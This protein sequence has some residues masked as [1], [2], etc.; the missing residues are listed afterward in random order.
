[1]AVLSETG[2]TF[3]VD[4]EPFPSGTD[5]SYTI[6]LRDSLVAADIVLNDNPTSNGYIVVLIDSVDGGTVQNNGDG[7]IT[8]RPRSGFFGLDTLTYALCDALCTN[9]CDT[10][11]VFIE[12]TSDFECFVPNGISPNG[13]GVNDNMNITCKNDYPDAVL[14]VFSR[15][16]TQVYE[17]SM[18]GFD[19]TFN[20]NDLPDGTY[21][22][23][24]EAE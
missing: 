13:D 22:Y 16:G 3:V 4:Y 9:N 23:F 19:G 15:W 20:G 21:F 5:D 24:L 10:M 2:D 6:V 12:V 1:M 11:S 8:Y 18:T 7:T 17:G 14:Q